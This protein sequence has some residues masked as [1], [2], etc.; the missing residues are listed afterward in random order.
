MLT[1]ITEHLTLIHAKAR[2]RHTDRGRAI[3]EPVNR[4][5]GETTAHL[6]HALANLPD[7]AERMHADHAMRALDTHIGAIVELDTVITVAAYLGPDIDIDIDLTAL[8]AERERVNADLTRNTTILV[9][10]LA[11]ARLDLNPAEDRCPECGTIA[12][13]HGTV[14]ERH[15]AGGGGINRTCSRQASA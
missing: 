5:L 4:A 2:L 3:A 8:R 6:R 14:H 13:G 10:A 9:Y 1:V 15:P 11:D 12:P 7:A